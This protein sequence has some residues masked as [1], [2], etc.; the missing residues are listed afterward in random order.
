MIKNYLKIILRNF[1][2]NKI[3]SFLNIFGLAIGLALVFLIVLY[4]HHETSYDAYNNN[5]DRIIRVTRYQK[6]LDWIESGTSYLLAPVLRDEYPEVEIVARTRVIGVEIEHNEKFE[7]NYFNCVDPEILDIL[8]LDFVYGSRENA[9]TDPYDILLSETRAAKHFPDENPVGK[10]LPVRMYGETINFTVKGVLKN[11]PTNS[12]FPMPF[13]VNIDLAKKFFQFIQNR[14][15]DGVYFEQWSFSYYQTYVLLK[16]D[17]DRKAFI[18]KMNK[19]PAKHHYE[20]M[21]ITYDIQPLKHIYLQSNDFTNNPTRSGNLADIYLFSSIAFLI[22]FIACTNFIILSTAQSIKR[23]KEIA[24]RKIVGAERKSLIKQIMFESVFTSFIAC[25]LAI[26]LTYL[27]RPGIVHFLNVPLDINYIKNYIYPL[28]LIVITLLVGL[29]SGS[30]VAFYISRLDPLKILKSSISTSSSKSLFRRIIICLQMTIFI[31][32]ISSSLIIYKQLYFVTNTNLGFDKEQLLTMELTSGD[33]SEH[34]YSFLDELSRNPNIF[35]VTGGF[36]LPPNDGRMIT[37][38]TLFDDPDQQIP[39]E[40]NHVDFNF[41]ETFNIE[42]VSGRSFSKKFAADTLNSI[43]INETA[44]KQLHIDDPIGKTIRDKEIIGIVKDFHFHSLYYEIE[45]MIFQYSPISQN[46]YVG[47]KLSPY[48]VQETIKF[49]EQTWSKFNTGKEAPFEF[50]F[51]D[52]TIDQ[53]YWET[54]NFGKA[55]S[56]CTLFAIFVACLGLFGLTMFITEQKSK[57]IGIRKVF[58]AS[59]FRI[60]KH[61]SSEI[62]WLTLISTV[63]AIPIVIYLMNKWLLNFAYK[64][65]ISFWI[66]IIAGLA[67]LSVSLLTMSFLSIKASLANPVD[68]MKYE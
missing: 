10:I 23:S 52:E 27:L 35:N 24:V 50:E 26:G 11:V 53:L 15:G 29:A 21:Q 42:M 31:G 34:Y 64:T 51:V 49:I 2:R 44:V 63:I 13:L 58:G 1:K 40:Y 54:Q 32:L 43:I 65:E 22:L 12:T 39:I 4:V 5:A 37:M 20:G 8:T 25:F 19:I 57:E 16:A 17:C 48:N 55:I 33:F 66:F 47:I 41:F 62:I 45:S 6:D 67:G 30:Y 36:F 28:S 3:Y 68:T 14:Y 9:L 46:G 7:Q 60:L 56:Y 38:E 59:S 18:D 61:L